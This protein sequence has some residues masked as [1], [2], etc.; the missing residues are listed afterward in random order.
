[1]AVTI[2]NGE[3]IDHNMGM[4][5]AFE[6]PKVIEMI[7]AKPDLLTEMLAKQTELEETIYKKAFDL[8]LADLTVLD[9]CQFIKDCTHWVTEEM[10]E[11]TRELP[12]M[13]H[14]KQYPQKPEEVEEMMEKAKKEFI[15]AVHFVLNIAV[16]F[17]MSAEDIHAMYMGK[18]KE[19]FNRQENN[20]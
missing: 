10:H 1:M 11:M 15:D 8:N 14:W 5:E 19:N 12:Y 13:K 9:K 4:R 20:Y 2:N 16:L 7:E 6:A 17:D 18:N 3:H